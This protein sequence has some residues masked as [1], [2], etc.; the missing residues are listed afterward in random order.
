VELTELA[1]DIQSRLDGIKAD[2]EKNNLELKTALEQRV[3]QVEKKGV[4]DP[5]LK[6][7]VDRLY[8]RHDELEAKLGAPD[9]VAGRGTRRHKSMGEAFTESEEYK[10]WAAAGFT[11]KVPKRVTVGGFDPSVQ[12]KAVITT[13]T[14]GSASTGVLSLDRQGFRDPLPMQRLFVRDLLPKRQVNSMAVDWLRQT[15][16]TNAAS[17]QVEGATKAESTY[18]WE[19]T[20]VPM[21]TIA[22]WTQVTTQALADAPW[23]RDE[24]D[25]EL[26][27]GLKIAEERELLVGDGLGVHISGLITNATAYSTALNISG[28]TKL[29]KLRHAKYQAR[30]ALYPPDGIVL[31]PK[32]LHDIELTK[33]EEGG[34]NKGA[35]LVGNPRTGSEITTIWGLPVVESDSMTIGTFLVG[36][37]NYGAVLFDRMAATIDISYEN[38]TNFVENEATIRC[39]ERIG[40]GVRRAGAFIYG[41][42]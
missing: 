14:L 20:S 8:T 40:L 4:A 28:D 31:H 21:R 3:E 35:Y 17:P 37:F 32:D 12:Y 19:A 15:T 27:F 6:E 22:H 9:S 33:T 42:F 36:A 38:G 30:L 5:E 18:A 1:N 2:I 11:G 7:R 23:L 25:S 24:I 34:A 10:S 41:T 13:G 39:E 29:D 26:M 16:R